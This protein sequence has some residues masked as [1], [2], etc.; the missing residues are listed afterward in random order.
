MHIKKPAPG[1]NLDTGYAGFDSL[2]FNTIRTADGSSNDPHLCEREFDTFHYRAPETEK[3]DETDKVSNDVF[4]KAVF[5]ALPAHAHITVT[6]YPGD[7]DTATGKDWGRYAAWGKTA[8]PETSNNYFCIASHYPQDN[9]GI[10][11][12]KSHFAA[13]HAVVL[14][15]VGAKVPVDRITLTP[16]WAIETS[17]G[18]F[19]YGFILA[20]PIEVAAEADRLMTAVI[21]AGLCDPGASGPTARNMRLPVAINGKSKYASETGEPFRCALRTW[22]PS[23][24]YSVDDL[25]A[26][27]E[28]VLPPAGRPK[29][30]REPR[31]DSLASAI[32][33]NSDDVYIPRPD[34][35]PVIAELKKR[36]LYKQPLGD[37]RHDITC[38]WVHEHTDAVDNGSAYFEPDDVYHIGGFKCQHS[39]GGKYRVAALLE[40]LG[41]TA[42]AARM[43]PTIRVSAGEMHRIV[44]RAENELAAAGRHYQTG[45][46][47][48]HISTDPATGESA[49]QPVS[50]PAL[51]RALSS[52]ALWERFDRRSEEWVRA[53][54]PARHCNVL[55]NSQSYA[56]LP[57]LA[58]LARQPYMRESGVIVS[59]AGYDR[60]SGMFGV[61]DARQFRI[62]ESPTKEDALLALGRLSDLLS[63]FSFATGSDRAAALS[64]LL[65]A[66]IRASLPHAPMFHSRAPVQGS[67]KSFLNKLATAFATPAPAAP[68]HFPESEEECGKLLLSVLMKSPAVIEFDDLTGD[69]QPY[70]ALKTAITEEAITGR[71]LGVSK[72]ATVSTRTLFL[73]SG[74]NV[75]PIR[76]MTRRVLTI[77]IDPLC[78]TPAT[79]RFTHPHLLQEVKAQRGAFVSDA[80]TIIKAWLTA[81]KPEADIPPIASF[82]DWSGLCRHSLIWLG[83]P[84]PAARMFEAMADDPDAELLGRLMIVWAE[85]IGTGPAMVR[86]LIDRGELDKGG[87]LDSVIREIA[88]ER[89]GIINRHRLGRWIKRHEGRFVGNMRLIPEKSGRNV[90]AWRVSVSS[91]SS[92]ISSRERNVSIS[93]ATAQHDVEVE[94]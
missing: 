64:M 25:V 59:T 4:I 44:D 14:D 20:E 11:R 60:E 91:V 70:S 75:G 80:F 74:N 10:R 88:E 32:D 85:N 69:I 16:S 86:D 29:R 83:L 30:S 63:E 90:S 6:S 71:I 21:D 50:A 93:R 61:F 92:V 18:N 2:N 39:H 67:G 33:A 31:H 54:P 56:H 87:E 81:G 36:G 42:G 51:T 58:G 82:A 40:F 13:L 52:V 89:G 38:P 78:E 48:V 3:T 27:F 43:K 24:H 66:A 35:N 79:R 12:V 22:N 9:G 49:I 23:L 41:V 5:H 53:D 17:P 73:S 84:D 19:Q 55:F 45:G 26:G 7:P 34:E 46:L 77:H 57:I 68:L 47:I 1:G 15:D 76:D 37:G 28:I 8:L 94:I 62:P 72:D 65:T